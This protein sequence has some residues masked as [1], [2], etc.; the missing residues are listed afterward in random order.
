M[1]TQEEREQM[2]V[3]IQQLNARL[4]QQETE[5]TTLAQERVRLA[6][7]VQSMW[8]TPRRR[9]QAGVVDTRVIGKPDQFDGDPMKYADWSF[10]LRS[11]L[12]A[13]DQRYQ[14]ELTTTE[15]SSTPRLHATLSREESALSTQMYYILVMT[16]C[17]SRVGQVPHGRRERRVRGLE[18]VRD[19]MGTQA[20][21]EVCGTP[22]ERAGVPIQRRQSHLAGG[23][24][25]NRTRLREQSTKTIDDDRNSVR[26]TS[27]TQMREEILEI[28]RTQQHIECQPV[29]MQ[30]GANPKSKGK[31]KESKGKGKDVEGKDKAKD[32]KNE[33]SKK[34]KSDDQRKSFH[35]NKSG[36]VKAEC[37]KR[38][39]DLADAEVKPVAASPHHHDTAAVVP[40]QCLLPDEKHSSTF[41]IA[42]PCANSETSCEFSSEQAV[43]SPG[44]GSI[45]PAETQ[46]VR[47]IAA[48]PSNETYLMMDTCASVSIFPRGFDQSATDV[49]TV[50]P[51]KLSTAT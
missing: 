21:D 27:W 14:Q 31:G 40:L 9:V 13:V 38:L 4:Q 48:I 32:A 24:R 7:Q 47:P 23:V 10:K 34:A 22:D 35:C 29:P 6:Q 45:A 51:Q 16:N 43:R 1:S 41:V 11:Y 5:M 18:A 42:M 46:R 39:M 37:R 8:S 33:S 20:S 19:G 26:I 44:A 2:A 25:E 36:H 15:A 50:A 49:S 12:G 30:L 28:T 3:A 17:R